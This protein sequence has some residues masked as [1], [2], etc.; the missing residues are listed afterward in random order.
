MESDGAPP[1]PAIQV[2]SAKLQEA[3]VAVM[4]AVHNHHHLRV[5]VRCGVQMNWTVFRSSWA[6]SSASNVRFQASMG[7]RLES[8]AEGS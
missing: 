5:L 2:T 7:V 3:A 1:A 4:L 8:G 6:D